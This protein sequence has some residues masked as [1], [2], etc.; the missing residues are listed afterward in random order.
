MYW[1][2]TIARKAE[3]MPKSEGDNARA[4]AK[5]SSSWLAL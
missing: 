3:A 1:K 5:L 4:N 2:L